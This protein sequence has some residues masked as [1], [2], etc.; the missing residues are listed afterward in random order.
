MGEPS[1][2]IAVTGRLLG[3]LF[4]RNGA[5]VRRFKLVLML[6]Q[7]TDTGGV[8]TPEDKPLLLEN[9]EFDIGTEELTTKR[10]WI[11]LRFGSWDIFEHE[12]PRSLAR[13]S[14][15]LPLSLF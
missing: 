14:I 13:T 11:N 6:E 2:I 15:D 3:N 5:E 4:T 9:R 1:F 10:T 8:K 7:G 12:G